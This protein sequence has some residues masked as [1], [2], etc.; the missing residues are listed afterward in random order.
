MNSEPKTSRRD[1]LATSAVAGGLALAPSLFAGQ[2][3]AIKVGL[4]GCG[5][6]G[7]GA[8][9]NTLIADSNVKLTAMADLYED[10]LQKSLETLQKSKALANKVD[11]KPEMMFT[12]FDGYMKVIDNC[13]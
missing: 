9:K 6:R 13:D 1:F 11:V 7:T 4:V 3:S 12:G 5:G 8:A 10:K 2:N